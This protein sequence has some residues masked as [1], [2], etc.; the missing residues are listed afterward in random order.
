[1]KIHRVQL[2]HIEL[3]LKAPFVTS[4]GALDYRGTVVIEVEDGEG[5]T[6][7]GESLAF[8]GPWYTEETIA[9]SWHMLRDY[10]IPRLAG[11]SL[12]TPAEVT[13][14]LAPVRGNLMAKA[15]LESAIWDLYAK[16]CGRPLAEVLGGQIKPLTLGAAVSMKSVP[17]MLSE[18]EERLAEGYRRIKLKIGPGKDFGYLT[19]VRQAFPELSLMADANGAYSRQD[20]ARLQT[21]DGLGLEMLEQPLAPGDWLGH[22]DLQAVLATSI[23]LDESIRSPEDLDLALALHSARVVNLKWGRV[24]GLFPALTMIDHARDHG[25]RIWCGGLLESGIGRAHSL[26]LSTV[27]GISVP[28]DVSAANRYWD[29]DIVMPEARLER[30]LLEIPNRPG[31]GYEV[32]REQ[33]QRVTK[34]R[35]SYRL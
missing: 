25:L 14:L 4:W 1:M 21:F 19:A 17:L 16:R 8:A 35:A 9:S 34:A 3:K 29:R 15:G 10:L 11:R 27:P 7:W 32:D 2:T 23:C 26:A 24:G 20:F 30:G 5:E 13:E 31:I 18:V 12:K 22:R 28:G 33:L 6:G